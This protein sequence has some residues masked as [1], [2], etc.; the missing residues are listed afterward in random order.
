MTVFTIGLQKRMSRRFS[1]QA[2]YTFT[3]AIDDVLNSTLA[4]EIQN[5][6]GVNLLAI[7]GLP[8]VGAWHGRG[9][10]SA[11]RRFWAKGHSSSIH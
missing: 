6:E 1:L 4:S 8:S 3:H 11:T 2:N 7:V 10:H 9:V 5:G